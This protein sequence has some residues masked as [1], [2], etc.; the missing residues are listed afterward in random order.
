MSHTKNASAFK[1]YICLMKIT[2]F[3]GFISIIFTAAHWVLA[4]TERRST[5]YNKVTV[6]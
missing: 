1:S 6:N 2:A 5:K 3:F 4:Q